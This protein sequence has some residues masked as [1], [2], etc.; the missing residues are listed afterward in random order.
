MDVDGH[1]GRRR[2]RSSSSLSGRIV[3]IGWVMALV[4]ASPGCSYIFT[5]GPPATPSVQQSPEPSRPTSPECTSSV[6]APVVD[7][8]LAVMLTGL[9]VVGVVAA[10]APCT[11]EYCDIGKGGGAVVGVIGVAT[12]LLFTASAVTGYRRTAD[13]RAAPESYPLPPA[14]ASLLPTS[15][16]EGCRPVDDAPR[17]CRSVASWPGREDR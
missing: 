5:R 1:D 2:R 16:V 15:P 17:L 8:V 12:G 4:A 7:T 11:G 9:G 3:R 13:C 14:T 10:T 6:A